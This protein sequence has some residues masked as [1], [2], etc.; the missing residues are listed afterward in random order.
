[1]FVPFNVMQGENRERS[2]WELSDRVV[3]GDPVDHWH[4]VGVFRAFDDLNRRLAVLGRLLETD[5]TLAKMHQHLIYSQAVQPGRKCRFAA[6]AANFSKELDKNFLGQVLGFRY[7]ARHPQAERIYA[8]IVALVKLL[9][10]LH[11]AFG[12][13]LR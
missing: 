9:E 12:S 3:Q 2:G 6:K 13:L 8:A 11:I 5:A 10:G 4:G 7:I 1:M